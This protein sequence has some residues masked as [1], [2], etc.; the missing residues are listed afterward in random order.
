MVKAA[1][2]QDDATVYAVR[3]HQCDGVTDDAIAAWCGGLDGAYYMAKETEASRVHYQGWVVT[4][5]KDVTLRLRIKKAF[6]GAVGNKG[7]SMTECKDVDAYQ[8]YCCKGTRESPPELVAARGVEYTA[9]W[10]AAQWEAF[11]RDERSTGYELKKAK[12]SADEVVWERVEK[13]DK[14]TPRHV[15]TVIV[16]VYTGVGKKFDMF[17]L[18]RFCNVIMS[19]YDKEFRKR[20]VAAA[21]QDDL[22]AAYDIDKELP[23]DNIRAHVDFEWV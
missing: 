10:V 21:M 7:Y 16:D 14:V 15:L 12:Q 3:I 19:R 20:L 2:L 5:L 6:P 4:R 18:K 17:Q 11:W 9:E 8:R 23:R 22:Y 13:L 1:K